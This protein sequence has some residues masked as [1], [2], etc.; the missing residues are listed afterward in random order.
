MITKGGTYDVDIP[1]VFVAR[2][3]GI[4]LGAAA[5]TSVTIRAR[6]DNSLSSRGLLNPYNLERSDPRTARSKGTGWPAACRPPRSFALQKP[7]LP[8]PTG[9][10]Q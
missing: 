8:A 9:P 7:S 5:P 4:A 6:G 10:P 1:G 2:C 3:T